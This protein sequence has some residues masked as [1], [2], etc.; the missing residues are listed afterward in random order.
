MA[1]DNTTYKDSAT[2]STT[3]YSLLNDANYNSANVKT[4][5]AIISPYV[6]AASIAAGDEFLV[7]IKEKINGQ[8]PF[9]IYQATLTFATPSV[10]WPSLHVAEGY[11]VTVDKIAGTDRV[12]HWRVG[13]IT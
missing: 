9:D 7:N 3:E 11:D 8:G 4:T 6:Y 12:I 10:S 13:L 5:P 1:L 2:I